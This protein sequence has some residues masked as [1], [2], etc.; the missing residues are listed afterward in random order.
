MYDVLMADLLISA[1][2]KTLNCL[3]RLNAYYV[4]VFLF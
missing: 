2:F 4:T 3:I 1:I